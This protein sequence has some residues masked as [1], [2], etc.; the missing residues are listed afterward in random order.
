MT[1]SRGRLEA[2]V[3]RLLAARGWPRRGLALV[4]GVLGAL[5]FPPYYLFPL[6]IV[7]LSGLALLIDKRRPPLASF[8][9][10]WWWGFGHFLIA[11]YWVAEAFLV[12]APRFGWMI[13]LI[14]GALAGWTALFI[15]LAALATRAVALAGPAK[16][17]AFAL[18]WTAAEWLRG[19]VLGGFP[20]D[21]A[22]Y[23]I[24]FSDALVQYAALGGAWGLSLLVVAFAAM[25]ATLWESKRRTAFLACASAGLAALL[26]YAGGAIRLAFADEPMVPHVVLRIVQPAIAQSAKWE[27]GAREQNV[28]LQRQLTVA[29]PGAENIS[30]AI[31]PETAVPFLLERDA[32]LRQW[33]GQAVPPGTLLVT[34]ALRGEPLSGDLG[35]VFNS[36]EAIDHDGNLLA[37]YD[38]FHL[39]PLGEFV[40]LR[41]FFPFVNKITPGTIDFSPGPGPR[42]LTL[43]GLPPVSPLICYEA[44]FPGRVV[45]SAKRP[46]WLLNLTNDGWFGTSSGPYQHFASARLRTV[47]EGLPLVRVAN[48]GISAL[49]DPYGRVLSEIGLGKSGVRDLPLPA[50]ISPPLYARFGDGTLLAQLLT[51]AVLAWLLSRRSR[52]IK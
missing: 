49:V 19:H 36:A 10:G 22:G 18:F 7:A 44:I 52:K 26:L 6:L 41:S 32:R 50:A 9:M 24:A 11:F 3:E 16:V 21:L 30:A 34:G 35:Q 40:P 23:S 17:L 28:A 5:A 51:A 48:T 46:Q 43:P 2:V 8:A 42:T 29:V 15:G 47:E 33:L 14:L 20:W 27:Q 45:D 39:V 12:D 13:P 31:W 37:S 1:D 4:L 38:K 25:P